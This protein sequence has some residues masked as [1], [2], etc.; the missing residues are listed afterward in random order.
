MQNFPLMD[1]RLQD[2]MENLSS[3]SQHQRRWGGR[4]SLLGSEHEVKLEAEVWWALRVFPRDEGPGGEVVTAVAYVCKSDE[5]RGH[6]CVWRHG[7]EGLWFLLSMN[8]QRHTASPMALSLMS[9]QSVPNRAAFIAAGCCM[10]RDNSLPHC[11][12]FNQKTFEV[13]LL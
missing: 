5:H 2:P 9:I 4:R 10:W 7:T 12:Q 13:V 8:Q 11:T 1:L 3:L 6:G